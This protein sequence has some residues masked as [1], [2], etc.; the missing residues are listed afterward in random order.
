MAKRKIKNNS[1]IGTIITLIVIAAFILLGDNLQGLNVLT[2]SAS[3][4][5]NSEII[6]NLKNVSII[7]GND[8]ISKI[9]EDENL[10]V[11]CLDVGQG[12]SI[13]ISNKGKNMLIDASTND[14]GSTVVKYLKQLGI[15]KID[16]LVGTHPHEDHIGG[17]DN[18][19]KNFDIGTIYMPKAVA[20]T[21]TYEDVIDAIANKKLKV[22]TPKIGDTFNIG[23][24]NC[25][26]MY[27]G[28]NEE[29]YNE[30]SIVIKMDFNNVSYLFTGDANENVENSREWPEVDILKVGHHGSSSSSTSK[31]LNQ[32]KP[33]VAL[34][35]VGKENK[36]GHPTKSALNRL[37]KIGAKTYRTDENETILIL[38]KN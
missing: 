8:C 9:P 33:K 16:Y 27:V 22:T 13:L 31:F 35:S 36:Y 6:E 19:I 4:N 38:E 14:M 34:I 3:D 12:D 26:V 20:T 17:L 29:E 25:E 1:I 7:T 11:Y 32:I 10:R 28:D 5:V 30:C 37:N 21:K 15:S 24:A 18:V 23:N 2:A